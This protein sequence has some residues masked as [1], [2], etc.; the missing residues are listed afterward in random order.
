MNHH[1]TNINLLLSSINIR[2][3]IGEMKDMLKVGREEF[4]QLLFILSFFISSDFLM[5]VS[6]IYK[7]INPCSK[8]SFF[9]FFFLLDTYLIG[10]IKHCECPAGQNVWIA[11]L[12]SLLWRA[13]DVRDSKYSELIFHIVKEKT[14]SP[15]WGATCIHTTLF[16]IPWTKTHF[17]QRFI[18]P[19][20]AFH[21]FDDKTC[22]YAVR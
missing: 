18:C 3:S 15:H 5:D 8:C 21:L 11:A 9:C 19:P 16:G 13:Q 17:F 1:L 4:H 7:K 2:T 20:A 14:E 10:P 22:K 12:G 6:A